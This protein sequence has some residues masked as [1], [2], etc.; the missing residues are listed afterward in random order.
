MCH[1]EELRDSM[2]DLEKLVQAKIEPESHSS[3]AKLCSSFCTW[4]DA[5]S[6][7]LND[8]SDFDSQSKVWT[9]TEI[10]AVLRLYGIDD[11]KFGDIQEHL[12]RVVSEWQ[13]DEVETEDEAMGVEKFKL[14]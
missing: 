2:K 5:F 6:D 3:L 9:G 13:A 12:A 7:N 8:Y 14:S 10:V 1:Q 4:M 11:R